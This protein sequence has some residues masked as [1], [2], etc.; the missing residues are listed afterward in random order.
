M[1]CDFCFYDA[2]VLVAGK[3]LDALRHGQVE[4]VFYRLVSLP[5]C[6][7]A[8]IWHDGV[9]ENVQRVALAVEVG[10]HGMLPPLLHDGE[11]VH[12]I[13]AVLECGVAGVCY[14]FNPIAHSGVDLFILGFADDVGY[15]STA[16]TGYTAHC[17]ILRHGNSPFCRCIMPAG[18]L[19][20]VLCVYDLSER[21]GDAALVVKHA[22][23]VH[24]DGSY[25]RPFVAVAVL[26]DCLE[27]GFVHLHVS[28]V[29]PIVCGDDLTEL[30]V[31]GFVILVVLHGNSPFC[32]LWAV[33]VVP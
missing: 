8:C 9:G 23:G 4:G 6:H 27:D 29:A 32:A 20:L 26:C 18:R 11:N 3:H 24:G 14:G 25:Q 7:S 13:L 28:D 5:I 15:G 19:L 10:D 16:Q 17:F 2:P 30:G 12:P 22:G 33:V 31:G 21:V 1:G